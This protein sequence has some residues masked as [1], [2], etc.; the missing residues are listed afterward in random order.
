[1]VLSADAKAVEKRLTGG[2][3]NSLGNT[4]EVVEDVLAD[5]RLVAPLLEAYDSEDEVVRLRVSSAVKRVTEAHPEWMLPH[6]GR[7]QGD[8]AQID[9]ASTK[10]TQPKLYL[11][12]WDLMDEG[13][14]E[15][16]KEIVR[17]NLE[18]DDD[19]IVQNNSIE[20]LA[21][22]AGEDR[23]L[24]EWLS[25]RLELRTEDCRK[26]VAKRASKA[27]EALTATDGG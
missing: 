27:L 10:W 21:I 4:I 11:A 7:L 22:W 26:S 24:R 23:V 18:A 1:M 13:Q 6:L 15:R 9:Q 2:H 3:P 12:L 17:R 16:S 5:S 19:W 8:I 20:A 25:P 14:R